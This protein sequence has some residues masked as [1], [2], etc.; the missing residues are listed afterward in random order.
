MKLTLY[1]LAV[2]MAVAQEMEP[3]DISLAP[4]QDYLDDL[5]L[6]KKVLAKKE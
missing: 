2:A 1:A 3:E 5:A 6:K 4:L